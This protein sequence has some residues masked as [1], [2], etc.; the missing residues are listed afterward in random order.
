[1]A[2]LINLLDNYIFSG[3]PSNAAWDLIKVAW[4]K[5]SQKSWEELYLDAF[6]VAVDEVR[7]RLAAY[8]E[9][10]EVALDRSA[11]SKVL[12]HDLGTA[13]GA[14]PFSK[15]SSEEFAMKLA[16]AME[17]HSVLVIGGHNLSPDDYAQLLRNLVCQANTRFKAA[18]LADELAFR[19]VLLDEALTNQALVDDVQ[20]YLADRFD[21]SE[22]RL[23]SAIDAA[24]DRVIAELKPRDQAVHF[25]GELKTQAEGFSQITDRARARTKLRIFVASP[26]DVLD[27]GD[28]LAQ[29]VEQLNQGLADRLGLT[30]ELLH[31]KTHVAPDAGRPQEVVFDQLPP[32]EWD[33]FVGILWLRFGSETGEIDPDTGQ[34]YSGTEE[35]FKAAYCRRQESTTGWPKVMF[36]RCTRAPTDMLCF[37]TAQY[38]RVQQ[39]FEDF[40]PAGRHPGLVQTYVQS[41]DFERLVRDH[42]EECLWE[43]AE[44][45]SHMPAKKP[46]QPKPVEEVYPSVYMLP[47]V[48]REPELRLFREMLKSETTVRGL[49][50]HSRGEGGWGKSVLLQM[51]K[52]ECVAYRAPTTEVFF[53][54]L[55]DT[56][57]DW[58]SIMDRTA[59]ELGVEHFPRYL[60]ASA[61][62]YSRE[63]R[64]SLEGYEEI[65]GQS[66]GSFVGPRRDFGETAVLVTSRLF[67][68]VGRLEQ[69]QLDVTELF[70]EELQAVPEPAQIVWLVDTKDWNWVEPDTQMW[71]IRVFR[72]IASG[73][74][75]KIILVAA[76]RSLLYSH[77]SWRGKVEELV[78][79]CFD[80]SAILELLVLTGW[81]RR[82]EGNEKMCEAIA[83]D[84]FRKTNGKPLDIC[85]CLRRG[86]PAWEV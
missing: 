61:T 51:F 40:A 80:K 48:D 42:L 35:E 21:L 24:A 66:S 20:V 60:S 52:K 79:G 32:E 47:P 50:I 4:E 30:L 73:K 69:F 17:A 19:R 36:Y 14:L 43:F 13:V 38:A 31:W 22:Q 71:L 3:V 54:D 7:P 39:F 70:L 77:P 78:A 23:Q 72:R 55:S 74:L 8:A 82:I 49:V 37:D 12:H 28:R 25:R 53:F 64:E 45:F 58:E 84:L 83:E 85:T 6:Q 44:S 33:I 46:E 11:L 29:V 10:G 1:M 81:I 59:R 18:I 65:Y 26:G 16:G 63:A 62:A 68:D 5:A 67:Y 56:G 34:P 57:A 9:E 76:G 75:T 86:Q 27:E 2:F 41:E 15:L